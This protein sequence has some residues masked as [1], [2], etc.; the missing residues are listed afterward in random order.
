MAGYRYRI[1]VE[2]LTDKKGQPLEKDTLTFETEN[3]DEILGIVE[4]LANRDDLFG[5]EKNIS[6]AVGLKLF[7]EAYIE[8]IKHPQFAPLRAPFKDFMMLLKRGKVRDRGED[9]GEE[10]QDSEA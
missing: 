4:K 9:T 1:T 2:P 7:S 8:N 5:R 3:H 10:K 6:F